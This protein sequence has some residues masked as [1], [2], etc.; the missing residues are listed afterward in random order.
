MRS[1]PLSITILLLSV[2]ALTGCGDSAPG[3]NTASNGARSNSNAEGGLGS[4][5]AGGGESTLNRAETVSPVL[6]AFCDAMTRKDETALRSVYSSASLKDLDA[7]VR[8]SG[9]KT[10]VAYLEAEQI[11]N[12]LCEVR[13][14]KITGDTAIAELRTEGAPNGFKVKLVKEGGAWKLTNES[15]DL[16]AVSQSGAK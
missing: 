7:K 8:D 15:P 2:F 12:K 11:S 13:N 6:K 14:E 1:N 9:T 3:P 5:P 4:V 16:E 10:I